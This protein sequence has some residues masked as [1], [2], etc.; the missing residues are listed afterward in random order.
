VQNLTAQRPNN[1]NSSSSTSSSNIVFLGRLC[2]LMV[3]VPGYRCRGPG[4][5]PSTTRFSRKWLVWNRVHSASWV[6]F[7]EL[8]ASKCRGSALENRDTAVEDP[9]RWPRD[10]LLSAKV[11]ADFADKRRSLGRYSSLTDSGHGVLIVNSLWD[12]RTETG[13]INVTSGNRTVTSF[14]PV[15]GHAVQVDV[16][17]VN[18][19]HVTHSNAC[20][21][22]LGASCIRPVPQHR[23]VHGRLQ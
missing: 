8:L 12:L 10:T 13:P 3:R 19:V 17:W 15:N 1:N 16:S 4:S 2:G 23:A 20:L 22:V 7:E 5:I 18:C 14:M 21:I 9:L 6:Q 11:G